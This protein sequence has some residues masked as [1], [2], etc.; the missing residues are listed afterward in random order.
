M[1]SGTRAGGDQRQRTPAMQVSEQADQGK[2]VRLAADIVAAHVRHNSVMVDEL[3]RLIRNVYGAL[4]GLGTGKADDK[5]RT[6]A[7]PVRASVRADHLVCLEDGRPM[8]TLKR[9]LMAEHGLTPAEYRLR[10]DLPA[11]YPMVAA[12][13]AA[14]RSAVARETGLGRTTGGRGRRKTRV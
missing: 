10:W 3:P 7:V 5:S 9:H 1:T 12:E 13:Y 14:R 4:A 8:K 11:D 2:L 6:P